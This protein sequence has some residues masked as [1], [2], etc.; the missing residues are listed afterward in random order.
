[1]NAGGEAKKGEKRGGNPRAGVNLSRSS[2]A[3]TFLGKGRHEK[4]QGKKER[5]TFKNWGSERRDETR[6]G[7]FKPKMNIKIK[8]AS[9]GSFAGENRG[10]PSGYT[11]KAKRKK[12][13]EEGKSPWGASSLGRTESQIG[14]P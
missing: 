10:P 7:T 1:V 5:G 4:S 6:L 11:K 12:L 9:L 14:V 2:R 8:A 13:R 3:R